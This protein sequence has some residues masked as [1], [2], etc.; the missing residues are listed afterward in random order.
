MRENEYAP[1]AKNYW[2][3]LVIRIYR[4]DGSLRGQTDMIEAYSDMSLK[5]GYEYISSADREKV[6]RK[7]IW[8]YTAPD[9]VKGEGGVTTTFIDPTLAPQDTLYLPSVRKVRRLAGAVSSQYFPG[10]DQ[11]LRRCLA[12]PGTAGAELQGRRIRAVQSRPEEAAIS[13]RLLTRGQ[14]RRRRGRRGGHH[15][16]NSQARC[17]LVV[18]KASVQMRTA[19]DE[20][21][22]RRCV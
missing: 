16:D 7:Y 5:K 11:S 9:E 19:G 17:Q 15:R 4:P 14:T 20:L 12:Y 8:T 18:F 21:F 6:L 2:D 10:L 22:L 13:A 1:Y 3:S